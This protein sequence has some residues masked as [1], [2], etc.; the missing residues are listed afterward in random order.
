[1]TMKAKILYSKLFK[2]YTTGKY[3]KL[4]ITIIKTPQFLAFLMSQNKVEELI[5]NLSTKF[6]S[7]GIIS[8][9]KLRKF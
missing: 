6:K 1:M 9:N 5:S 7:I 3:K 2:F 4:T 8:R